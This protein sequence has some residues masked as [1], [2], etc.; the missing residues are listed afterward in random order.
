MKQ[1]PSLE[2]SNSS[3]THEIPRILWEPEVHYIVQNSPPLVSVQS[4]INPVYAIHPIEDI[5]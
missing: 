5:C 2:A 4:Q 1:T 3:E